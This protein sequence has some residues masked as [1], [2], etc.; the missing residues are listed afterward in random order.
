MTAERLWAITLKLLKPAWTP[1][2]KQGLLLNNSHSQY[3]EKM[4]QKIKITAGMF[5]SLFSLFCGW[6]PPQI[7]YYTLQETQC[8]CVMHC[9][10][11]KFK[12]PSEVQDVV[13][14][15]T[16]LQL[17]T[18]ND[19]PSNERIMTLNRGSCLHNKWVAVIVLAWNII[20]CCGLAWT[21]VWYKRN[22]SFMVN[23]VNALKAFNR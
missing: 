3:S 22:T 18:Q 17:S 10:K 1:Q 2:W 12:R 14:Q 9:K 23:C 11:S 6:L 19:C 4:L 16:V 20:G 8:G 7:V 21:T 5:F 13:N 15:W